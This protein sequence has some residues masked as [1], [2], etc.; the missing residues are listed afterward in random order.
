ML[1]VT[2]QQILWLWRRRQT[3]VHGRIVC[4]QRRW[5][6]RARTE[7]YICGDTKYDNYNANEHLL[8]LCICAHN[9]I[10][11]EEPSET[12][13]FAC[14]TVCSSSKFFKLN[15]THSVKLLSNKSCL[16]T[17]YHLFS[18]G[19]VCSGWSVIRNTTRMYERRR[20]SDT[21][22]STVVR[23]RSFIINFQ[24]SPIQAGALPHSHQRASCANDRRVHRFFCCALPKD[25]SG[26]R[27]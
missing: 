12:F 14:G 19:Q 17:P 16:C 3:R 5:C 6:R 2:E 7:E 9:A 20:T 1:Y 11:K 27:F 10:A 25:G 18:M 4:G 22:R 24:L 23:G 15:I 26:L 8:R 21:Q 13:L